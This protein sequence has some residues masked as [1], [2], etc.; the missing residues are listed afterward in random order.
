M[1]SESPTDGASAEPEP[2][3]VP[4]LAN[5]E[6]ESSSKTGRP[7]RF[8]FDFAPTTDHRALIEYTERELRR[9][10]ANDSLLHDLPFDVTID[11]VAAQV[12]RARR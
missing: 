2:E 5:D 10:F 4:T 11:E 9:L 8:A 1:E 6:T 12:S 3:P 7:S